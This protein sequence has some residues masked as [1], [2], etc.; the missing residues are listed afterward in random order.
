M[1]KRRQITDR[2]WSNHSWF[3]LWVAS[4]SLFFMGCGG[5]S[6]PGLPCQSQQDCHQGQVCTQGTC[7]NEQTAKRPNDPSV[8]SQEPCQ[9]AADCS[10]QAVCVAGRCQAT[11]APTPPSTCFPS[12]FQQGVEHT[13]LHRTN[14]LAV[15]NDGT[16]L[17]T[18]HND[19][20]KVWSVKPSS[21]APPELQHVLYSKGE[22][23][24]KIQQ[25]PDQKQLASLSR[26]GIK[27]WDLKSGSVIHQ[28]VPR[29]SV[30][31]MAFNAEGTSFVVVTTKQATRWNLPSGK[32][33][34]ALSFPLWQRGHR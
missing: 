26:D 13:S 7:H 22:A 6:A 21:P 24:L 31:G 23:F 17:A 8:T 28:W 25:S 18:A 1:Y 29:S 4:L 32:L 3:P 11:S 9:Q 10:S 20:L 34:H 33:S 15:S 12:R 14:D 19:L 30:L 27:L 2:A 5:L 16:S